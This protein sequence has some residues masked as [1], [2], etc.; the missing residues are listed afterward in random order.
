MMSTHEAARM[1]GGRTLGADVRFDSVSSD[2]RTLVPGALFVALRGERFDGHAFIKAARERGAAA[3][4]IDEQAAAA[5]QAEADSPGDMPRVVVK[6]TRQ[7]LGRLAAA[8]RKRLSMPLIVVA[9]SNG[10]TTV[11]GMI[12]AI[13]AAEFGAGRSLATEGNFNNDIGLPL[14]L[15]RLRGEHRAAVVELGINHPGETAQL[16]AIAQPTV[17]LVNNAQREH[18]EFMSSVADVAA[19]HAAVFDALP[20]GGVAVINA[21]DDYA[22]VWRSHCGMR[23]H[24]GP[25]WKDGGRNAQLSH[26]GVEGVVIRDFGIDKPAEVTADYQFAGFASDVQLRTPEGDIAFRLAL[27]GAHNVRNAVAATAAAT[28][29]GASL[30]SVAAGLSRFRALKGRLQLREG[31]HGAT[32][33]DDSYNANPDSVRAAIDVLSRMAGHRTLIIGDMGEVGEQ[34]EMFHR[35]VGRYAADAGIDEMRALGALAAHAFAAFAEVRKGGGLW[36]AS[37][38]AL[39]EDLA[40]KPPGEGAILVKGS[41]FMRMERVVGMLAEPA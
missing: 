4:L 6:D 32:V 8:W 22:D 26:P 15:L 39:L 5:A 28:A 37:M 35:E 2:T 30:Q 29:A 19:E 12:A 25:A 16:A 17:A 31:R 21:D 36:Y 23:E 34:G 7:G 40:E 14:T 11:A 27:G 41:R 3:A 9:G 24:P 13:L 20:P 10:K 33:I 1:T 18:Q 38:D